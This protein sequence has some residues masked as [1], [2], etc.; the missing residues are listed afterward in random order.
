MPTPPRNSSIAQPARP[1]RP[2]WSRCWPTGWIRRRRFTAA[3]LPQHHVQS[4]ETD[5]QPTAAL[6]A[7]YSALAT[8]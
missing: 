2:T 4:T 5:G 3:A 1:A 6:R 7:F 8:F